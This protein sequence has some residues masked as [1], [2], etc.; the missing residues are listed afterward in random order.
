MVLK[1]RRRYRKR[2]AIMEKLNEIMERLDK[3]GGSDVK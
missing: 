3:L 1:I 2:D